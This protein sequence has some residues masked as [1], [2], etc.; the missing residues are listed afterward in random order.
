MASAWAYD[1][2]DGG[3]YYNITSVNA[4]YR[5]CVTNDD[6]NYN[7]YSGS[8]TIPSSVT[9]NSINYSVTSIGANAFYG[10]S[11]LTSIVIP[12]SVT[13]INSGA[14][15]SCSG[16][17][18]INLPTSLKTIELLAFASCTG[19]T[20]LTLPSSL[21]TIGVFAFSGCS[22]LNSIYAKNAIPVVL[23]KDTSAF[24]GVNTTC[25]LHVP[26]GTKS[27]YQAATI[28]KNFTTITADITAATFNATASNLKI[29][30][31]NGK[32]EISGLPQG[33]SVAVYNLQ[34]AAIYNQ[35]ATAESVSVNLPARGVYV[36]KVGNE[37]VKVVY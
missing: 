17:T 35:K 33:A 18:S 36:V 30:T 24:N 5:V 26:V 19:L 15:C 23:N 10:C 32:A 25:V 4:P 29:N 9:Y 16:L 31:N 11:S 28:W 21:S 13:S 14:F 6:I 1:F 27:A 20:S 2:T 7:N 37:S 8:V 34:G 12:P 3:I 22:S